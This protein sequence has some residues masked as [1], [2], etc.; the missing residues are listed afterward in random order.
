MGIY[1]QYTGGTIH[2]TIYSQTPYN[3]SIHLVVPSAEDSSSTGGEKAP[4]E[5]DGSSAS[6]SG[7]G[8]G[9][10][11]AIGVCGL[12]FMSQAILFFFHGMTSL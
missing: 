6:S 12:V 3:S 10:E 1:K 9:Q 5:V 7:G 11:L 4:T 8:G 2:E